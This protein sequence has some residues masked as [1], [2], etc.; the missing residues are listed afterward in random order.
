MEAIDGEKDDHVIA[1]ALAAI[2]VI[3]L[4]GPRAVTEKERELKARRDAALSEQRKGKKAAKR[5]FGTKSSTPGWKPSKK[6]ASVDEIKSMIKSLEDSKAL[7]KGTPNPEPALRI[8]PV[9][10]RGL[11]PRKKRWLG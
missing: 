2:G 11:S 10:R 9:E 1:R 4:R 7:E 8:G 6:A 3:S 5:F